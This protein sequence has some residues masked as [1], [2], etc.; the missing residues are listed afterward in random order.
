MAVF[1]G[2]C[3]IRWPYT[4]IS[5]ISSSD[6]HRLRPTKLH[7]TMSKKQ[8]PDSPDLTTQSSSDSPAPTIR[9]KPKKITKTKTAAPV[10]QPLP[11]NLLESDTEDLTQ[12]LQP[13]TQTA[14]P[15]AGTVA[16]LANKQEGGPTGAVS[17]L[18][19]NG[20][21][22]IGTGPTGRRKVPT[23]MSRKDD[24]DASKA[25]DE[26]SSLRIKVELDLEV[27]VELWAR[28]KGDVTIGL[29]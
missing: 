5:D 17:Q 27:E 15:V 7:L 21:P 20:L 28:V 13:V 10:Q 1:L 29:L 22:R 26:K 19:E 8:A 24:T 18:N 14:A 23:H 16:G 3:V 11:D 2:T 25:E 12:A 4:S 6:R 9:K